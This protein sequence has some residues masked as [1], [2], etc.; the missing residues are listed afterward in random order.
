MER[1]LFDASTHLGQ[2]CLDNEPVR[3]GCKNMHIDFM[4][5]C[6]SGAWTDLENGRVDRTIW[7]LPAA[8]Q[9]AYYPFMDQF[10]SA[11]PVDQPTMNMDIE[12]MAQ[13][14]RVQFPY[15]SLYS[16]YGVAMA[17][18]QN[19]AEIHTLFDEMFKSDLRDGLVEQHEIKII[20]PSASHEK[21]YSD[22]E[23]EKAYENAVATF[24][25]AQ[26][27]ILS[28][29]ADRRQINLASIMG[30]TIRSQFVGPSGI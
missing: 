1:I 26:V 14:L 25:A 18:V 6:Q 27:D 20:Y 9:N 23:L 5:G 22:V 12:D 29:L 24:R 4:E 8:L 16:R 13:K 11:A 17:I 28:C 10:F 19:R 21:T 30:S 3:I 7:N 15:L 2:F